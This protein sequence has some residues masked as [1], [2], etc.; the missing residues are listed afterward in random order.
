MC[1]L[2]FSPSRPLKQKKPHFFFYHHR[3][4]MMASRNTT[5]RLTKYTK[6]R[7]AQSCRRERGSLEKKHP[8]EPPAL[9]TGGLYTCINICGAR[10]RFLCVYGPA[11]KGTDRCTRPSRVGGLVFE[12]APGQ[13]GKRCLLVLLLSCWV[14]KKSFPLLVHSRK[15]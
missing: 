7:E 14:R 6:E 10:H 12:T 13:G 9:I 3:G 4:Y 15:K 1:A 11:Q 5:P 2:F 8:F